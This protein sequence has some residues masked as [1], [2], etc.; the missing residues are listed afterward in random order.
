M[1]KLLQNNSFVYFTLAAVFLL[2]TAAAIAM[3]MFYF[4]ALPYVFLIVWMA[5]KSLDKLVFLIIFMVPISVPLSEFVEAPINM[6]MPTEPLLAGLLL[7]FIILIPTKKL[8]VKE[9]I[10][11]PVTIASMILMVWMLVTTITSTMPL[12][13]IKF[14]AMRLWFLIVF[15]YLI[16]MIVKT[17][18]DIQNFI[19]LYAVPMVI[20]IVYALVRHMT[21]GIFD[22]K[23]AHWASNPFYKDHTIY[24]ATLAFYVPPLFIMAIKKNQSLLLRLFTGGLFTIFVIALIFSYSRAAW[25]SV[26]GAGMLYLVLRLRIN[27]KYILSVSLI[28]ILT[29][30]FSWNN[31]MLKLEQ[32]RQESSVENIGEHV[33]SVTNI[34][35]DASNLERINRWA[36]AFRMFDEKP[37][38]GFGPGTYMFQYAPYQMSYEKTII[39]TNA[40]DMGNA[41]SE[42]FGPLSEQGLPGMLTYLALITTV[43][44]IGIKRFYKIKDPSLKN[45]MAAAILGLTTYY[46]HAFLNNFLDTDKI[47]V[48]FWGFTAIIVAIDLYEKGFVK[49]E[50]ASSKTQNQ[51]G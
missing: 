41:H 18:K 23:I 11:H 26:I 47:S 28:L 24:G 48:P 9:I 20:V 31:I 16:A 14:F 39:S 19:W 37:L 44:I 32:N 15:Y 12:V 38:L 45:Y 5:I 50:E 51:I 46:L 30:V 35:N 4:L 7:L 22:S 34:R 1:K 36:S 8:I 17:Q 43:L 21:Y 25:L 27:W 33:K 6:F 42:Y 13:S 29:L 2:I 3:E 49:N 10:Y 40:G